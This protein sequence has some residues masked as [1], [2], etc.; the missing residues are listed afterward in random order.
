MMECHYN[1]LS[2][3]SPHYAWVCPDITSPTSWTSYHVIMLGALWLSQ[4]MLTWHI[5]RPTSG[6]MDKIQQ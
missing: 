1:L 4:L 6:R 2:L 3:S 5:W